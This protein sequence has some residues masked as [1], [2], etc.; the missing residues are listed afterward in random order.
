M[1]CVFVDVVDVFTPLDEIVDVKEASSELVDR[2]NADE[3]PE[4]ANET[5]IQKIINMQLDNLY[6]I[7]PSF[8]LF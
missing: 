3:Q 7:L 6:D 4:L 2:G 5:A 8:D 1:A